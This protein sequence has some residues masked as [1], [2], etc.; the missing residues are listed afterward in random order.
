MHGMYLI[1]NYHS[2][3]LEI[4]YKFDIPKYLNTEKYIKD[5]R[6]IEI[7]NFEFDFIL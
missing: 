5:E 7:I 2:L 4:E 1:Q 3:G 6:L